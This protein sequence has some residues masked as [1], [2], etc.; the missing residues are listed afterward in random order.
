M[1]DRPAGYWRLGERFGARIAYNL[2]EGGMGVSGYYSTNITFE[3]PSPVLNDKS[4]LAVRE[5]I[6]LYP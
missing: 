4:K 1:V 5:P 3:I 2:G 6:I